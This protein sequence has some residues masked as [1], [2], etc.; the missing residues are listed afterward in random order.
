[1]INADPTKAAEELEKWAA[2]LEQRAERYNQ[3]Q[4]QLDTTSAT[5]TS[6]DG[7][8]RVTVDANGVPTDIALSDRTRGAEPAQVSAQIMAGMR[9]AQA[10][11]RQQVQALIQET[12]PADDEPARNLAAQYEQRFPDVPDD[13]G[14][15]YEV[16]EDMRIGG[17]EEDGP[18][19]PP[20]P[21]P[22]RRPDT[23]E[24]WDDQTFLR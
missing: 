8:V 7:T 17:I 13:R 12:V 15:D 1:M 20:A 21:R 11:L 4:R 9:K 6:P 23:D 2:G 3:L 18:A 16:A 10:Q 5:A 14:T 19:A 22:A 24:G